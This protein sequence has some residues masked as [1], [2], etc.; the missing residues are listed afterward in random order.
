MDLEVFPK[1]IK[2]NNVIEYRYH[3]QFSFLVDDSQYLYLKNKYSK[4][5][6]IREKR[7]LKGIKNEFTRIKIDKKWLNKES[8]ILYFNYGGISEFAVCD[9]EHRK[10]EYVYVQEPK[11]YYFE[12]YR[13][14]IVRDKTYDNENTD[15]DTMPLGR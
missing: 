14:D 9:N 15:C 6:Y 13:N 10:I 12:K 1:H 3:P 7:R 5:D 2:K 11:F 4:K 8:Y